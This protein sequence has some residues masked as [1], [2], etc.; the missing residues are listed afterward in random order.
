MVGVGVLS[1]RLSDSSCNTAL[2]FRVGLTGVI[3]AWE[4]CFLP[5]CYSVLSALARIVPTTGSSGH[6]RADAA[7]NL[8]LDLD[9]NRRFRVSSDPRAPIGVIR[10]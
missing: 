9:L 2:G 6:A 4:I 10:K 8:D 7:L 1:E 5:G 3:V